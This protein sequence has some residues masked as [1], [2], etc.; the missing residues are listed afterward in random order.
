[1]EKD[2][3][4]EFEFNISNINDTKGDE[5]VLD[6]PLTV[7]CRKTLPYYYYSLRSSKRYYYGAYEQVV[8]PQSSFASCVDDPTTSDVSCG[9]QYDE[10]T[11]SRIP[12]SQ[13]FCCSCKIFNSNSTDTR[14]RTD[15]WN[16][17]R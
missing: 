15:V 10:I 4:E 14:S 3:T 2:A 17:F 1:M 5:Y 13:G 6:T 11:G 12:Y 9:F 8:Y 7:S 16:F